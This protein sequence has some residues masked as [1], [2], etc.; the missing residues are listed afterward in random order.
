[1][2][3]SDGWIDQIEFP[4]T[5]QELI[6]AADEAGADQDVI[7]RLQALENEQ[8]ESREELAAELGADA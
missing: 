8:Y 7:E 4:A 5:K 6:E 3:P 2:A 1:M